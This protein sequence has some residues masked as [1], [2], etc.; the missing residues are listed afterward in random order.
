MIN[1]E[2]FS[3]W[4]DH[5]ITKAVFEILEIYEEKTLEALIGNDDRDSEKTSDFYRGALLAYRDVL[6]IS[7]GDVEQ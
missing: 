1:E 5:P 7:V 2:E 3:L 4:K 6:N